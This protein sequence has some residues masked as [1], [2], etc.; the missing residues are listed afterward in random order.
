M[1]MKHFVCIIFLASSLVYPFNFDGPLYPYIFLSEQSCVEDNCF[2]ITI[3]E[4]HSLQYCIKL[5]KP[6]WFWHFDFFHEQEKYGPCFFDSQ[7]QVYEQSVVVAILDTKISKKDFQGHVAC[8]NC[9][10]LNQVGNFNKKTTS[11]ELFL[12]ASQSQGALRNLLTPMMKKK[13]FV[14]HLIKKN[15]GAISMY[16]IKQIAPHVQI[17]SIPILNSDAG[18]SKQELLDGLQQALCY[19]VDILHLGLQVYNMDNATANDQKIKH[20]L[21][22]FPYVV[23]PAGNNG[24]MLIGYPAQEKNVIS[25]GACK[26]VGQKYLVADF[27]QASSSNKVDFI[28]PGHNIIAPL[29]IEEVQDYILIPTTGTSMSAALMSGVLALILEKNQ[30]ALSVDQI[31]QLLYKHSIQLDSSW[32]DTVEY[33]TPILPLI[34]QDIDTFKKKKIRYKK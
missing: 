7:Q 18:C 11:I 33:G 28:L 4:D 5:L 27:S 24:T 34:F 2:D 1:V 25:V 10:N 6:F 15:H 19:K 30:R 29:W 17:I 3:V 21:Q 23:A 9:F 12:K 32:R 31:M 26:K 14:D 8:A 22:Q 20:I 16:L 13:T